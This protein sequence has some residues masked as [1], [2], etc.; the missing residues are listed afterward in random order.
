MS[1]DF[2]FLDSGTGGIPYMLNLYKKFPEAKCVYLGDT[3][4]FP[5]GE[6][7]SREVTECASAAIQN[8]INL[9][10]PKAI[11][12]ACNTISV[13]ALSD[14]RE[15][16]PD[17]PIIGTVPAIKLAAKVTKNKKIGLL[18][19]TAT[20]NHPYCQKLISD[21][22]SDCEVF[23]RADPKLIDF[24][25][26]QYFNSNKDERLNAVSEAAG[27]FKNKGC[28]TVILGCTH[29]THI[30][31]EMRTACGSG[32]TVVD[33]RDGVAN[34]AIRKIH[35]ECTKDKNNSELSV[36]NLTFFVTKANESEEK[37]YRELCKNLKIPFG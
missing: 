19:T 8:I 6:K 17:L 13:T 18:A 32:I 29:F 23:M 11:V 34:Q 3:L 25:E 37:E 27:Y 16:F 31:Q 4:N 35:N 21:F 26:K 10:S 1:V 24:V 33:S 30:A 20:V 7:S 22:A 14:L 5:Y 9:W 36:Q 15:N 28:D 12:V 2:A